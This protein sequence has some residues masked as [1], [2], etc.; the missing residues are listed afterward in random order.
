MT[1]LQIV[2]GQFEENCF[3]TLVADHGGSIT[4]DVRIASYLKIPYWEYKQKLIT[5]Y[6]AFELTHNE[7]CF[8]NR[9]DAQKAIDEYLAPHF[10]MVLITS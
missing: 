7:I 10:V 2:I 6:N 9:E 1:D 4:N 5:D 3:I 8:R